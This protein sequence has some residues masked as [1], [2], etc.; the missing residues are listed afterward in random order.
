MLV[1]DKFIVG[2]FLMDIII[3]APGRIGH[4]GQGQ[5]FEYPEYNIDAQKKSTH[6]S[7]TKL[8]FGGLFV[9]CRCNRKI[10]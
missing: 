3:I 4:Y 5:I 2:V 10:T 8:I 7:G 6:F 9:A 1:A